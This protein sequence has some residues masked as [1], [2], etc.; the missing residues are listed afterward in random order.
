MLK[1]NTVSSRGFNRVS[2]GVS[3]LAEHD[4]RTQV[5]ELERAAAERDARLAAAMRE[6]RDTA[7]VRPLSY[8]ILRALLKPPLDSEGP[9][10]IP[11]EFLGPY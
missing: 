9:I 8:S 1:S 10:E 2:I 5:A 4:G 7:E 3:Y 6:Q 11:I